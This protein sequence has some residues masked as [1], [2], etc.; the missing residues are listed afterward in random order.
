MPDFMG[1]PMLPVG[2]TRVVGAGETAGVASS[3]LFALVC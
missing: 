3:S 2:L 1:N